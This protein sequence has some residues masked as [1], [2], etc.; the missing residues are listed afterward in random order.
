M[1][2][3]RIRRLLLTQAFYGFF[4]AETGF[5]AIGVLMKGQNICRQVLLFKRFAGNKRL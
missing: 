2:I 4:M 5:Y 1:Q 3:G